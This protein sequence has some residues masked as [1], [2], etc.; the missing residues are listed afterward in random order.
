MD[1]KLKAKW[2][3]ALMSG[4]YKQGVDGRLHNWAMNTYCCLGVLR[5]V[6][7]PKDIS[8]RHF[9]EQP[10]GWI[11]IKK[12]GLSHKI[13]EGLAEMNDDGVPF[14]VIAGFIQENL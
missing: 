3:K 4:K 6:N 5:H 9:D 2:V 13:Q 12:F 10:N 11:D 8:Y 7:D 1:K 14:P